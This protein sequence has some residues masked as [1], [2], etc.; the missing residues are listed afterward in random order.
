MLAVSQHLGMTSDAVPGIATPFGGGIG[1]SGSVC[2]AVVGGLM[3]LGLKFGRTQPQ[4]S[5]ASAYARAQE[6]YRRFR[7]EMGSAICYELTGFDLT[8]P[9]GYRQ[10]RASD[11]PTRVCRRAVTTA[12][13]LAAELGQDL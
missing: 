1:R 10:F 13:R 9:D 12:T 6:L 4:E 3:A 8:T 2:G 11:V 5:N 7:Q